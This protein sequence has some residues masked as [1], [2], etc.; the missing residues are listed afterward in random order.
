M[1]EI[2]VA[3]ASLA[4]TADAI[5]ESQST[6]V[7]VE[8]PEVVT[9]APDDDVNELVLLVVAVL[10]VVLLTEVMTKVRSQEEAGPAGAGPD[11]TSSAE[12]LQ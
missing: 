7:V 5:S 4:F 1:V 6:L 10:D 8:L 12:Q 3:A 11:Q 9:E 2:E